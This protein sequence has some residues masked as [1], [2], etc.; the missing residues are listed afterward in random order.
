MHVHSMICDTNR[1]RQHDNRRKILF[2]YHTPE[3]YNGHI[4]NRILGD[5]KRL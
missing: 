5:N 2:G 4:N 1:R 3:I